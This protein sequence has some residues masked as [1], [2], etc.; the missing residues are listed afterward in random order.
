MRHCRKNGDWEI[1]ELVTLTEEILNGKPHFL[2][3]ETTTIFV[4][5]L[6]GLWNVFLNLGLG[7]FEREEHYPILL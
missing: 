4:A 2:C 7:W 6:R 3:T 1:A 5:E